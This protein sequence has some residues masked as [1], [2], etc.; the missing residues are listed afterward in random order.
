MRTEFRGGSSGKTI[1]LEEDEQALAVLS[2]HGF[3]VARAKLFITSSLGGGRGMLL[4]SWR[5]LLL[6]LLLLFCYPLHCH[7]LY[8]LRWPHPFVRPWPMPCRRPFILVQ[9]PH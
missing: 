7:L 8:L 3:D 5:L 1:P 4:A 2:H 9:R 6:L